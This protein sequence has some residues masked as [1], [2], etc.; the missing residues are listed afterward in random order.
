MTGNLKQL[1][2]DIT[3]AYETKEDCGTYGCAGHTYC[4]LVCSCGYTNW[5]GEHAMDRSER[6]KAA[7]QAHKDAVI[8][9]LLGVQFTVALR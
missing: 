2:H 3:W 1:T 6:Q 8:A 7:V 5:L 4:T 9:A